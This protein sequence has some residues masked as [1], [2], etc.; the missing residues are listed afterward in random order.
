[1]QKTVQ[2]SE[3]ISVTHYIRDASG[4][5]LAT[6]KETKIEEFHIYGSSHLG[7]YTPKTDDYGKLV[8][9]YHLKW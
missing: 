4:N 9:G 2:K 8:L 5:I 3:F 1:M 7:I 6:Y